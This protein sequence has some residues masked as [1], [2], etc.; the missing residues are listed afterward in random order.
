MSDEKFLTTPWGD[1]NAE[2]LLTKGSNERKRYG[3]HLHY[4]S[5]Q[6]IMSYLLVLI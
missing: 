4:F 5:K 1:D 3:R 6:A 2:L